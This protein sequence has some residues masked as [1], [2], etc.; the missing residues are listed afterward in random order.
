[1]TQAHEL[2]GA[3]LAQGQAG[4]DALDVGSAVLVG[5]SQ[6]VQDVA[7]YVE[8][9]RSGFVIVDPAERRRLIAEGAAQA[10]AAVGGHVLADEELLGTVTQLV[11]Y[12]AIAVGRFADA[13]LELPAE[14]LITAMREHQKYFAV[15]D[16]GGGLLPHFIAVNNT[17]VQDMA[18]VVRG[19]ERVLRARL[20]D[21]KFFF[22][23]DRE[24]SLDTMV[25]KLKSVLF[26]AQL[27][28]IYD[29][30]RRVRG[31]A[32]FV[33]DLLGSTLFALFTLEHPEALHALMRQSEKV[34][35]GETFVDPALMSALT[36]TRDGSAS[37]AASAIQSRVPSSRRLLQTVSPT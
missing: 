28:T 9:L 37:S 20:E 14:V 7:A 11:E 22:K 27:G 13:F 6:G 34:A 3:H 29:K 23:S 16:A 8:A 1:M 17:P 35:A 4:G 15:V 2:A 33:A 36:K 24:T 32:R 19:H 10:A 18:V 25:E 21:A 5:W 12:P 30:V 26:Q 31:L